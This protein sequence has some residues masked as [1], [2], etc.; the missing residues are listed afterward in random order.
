MRDNVIV[1]AGL[2]INKFEQVTQEG[3]L[4]LAKGDRAAGGGAC[5]PAAQ[6]V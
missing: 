1:D 5:D 2:S 6:Q 3:N 4:V